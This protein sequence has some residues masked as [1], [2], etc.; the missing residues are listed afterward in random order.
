MDCAG[1]LRRLCTPR[2]HRNF[3][4]W[5]PQNPVRKLLLH[6]DRPEKGK[7]LKP[8]KGLIFSWLPHLLAG[9]LCGRYG[10][11]ADH[12]DFVDI[13][14]RLPVHLTADGLP[15]ESIRVH[16]GIDVDRRC[17]MSVIEDGL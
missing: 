15:R 12:C 14:Q 17:S 8:P 1:P 6:R 3:R 13:G 5:L 11:L 7:T 10:L 9:L 2:H 4:L 16:I